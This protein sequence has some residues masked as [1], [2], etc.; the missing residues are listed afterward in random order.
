MQKRRDGKLSNFGLFGAGS[1]GRISEFFWGKNTSNLANIKNY[2]VQ[3]FQK[4]V[5]LL[6]FY[7]NLCLKVFFKTFKIST[8]DYID[9]NKILNDKYFRTQ[10]LFITKNSKYFIFN[11]PYICFTSKFCHYQQNAIFASNRERDA[12][13]FKVNQIQRKSKNK[14][15]IN[16]SD[17][18]MNF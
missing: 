8:R 13:E 11:F 7:F 2:I 4:K 12:N 3:F 10:I 9:V 6:N 17:I 5:T 14:F 15:G 1:F 16:Y 18:Q